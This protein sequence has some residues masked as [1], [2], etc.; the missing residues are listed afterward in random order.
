MMITP[1]IFARMQIR[2]L[3]AQ[4]KKGKDDEYNLERKIQN[5]ENEYEERM[6][7]QDRIRGEI[8]DTEAECLAC[9][10]EIDA[11]ETEIAALREKEWPHCGT[12]EP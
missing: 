2:S 12:M 1:S 9:E 11:A 10:G 4:V 8:G 7:R 6:A 5:E 3:E